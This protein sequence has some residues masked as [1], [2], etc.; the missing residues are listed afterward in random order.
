[1]PILDM[2]VDRRKQEAGYVNQCAAPKQAT[3]AGLRSGP[4]L[5]SRLP[6]SGSPS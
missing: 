6:T 3:G 2:T 5:P 4:Q 1:M